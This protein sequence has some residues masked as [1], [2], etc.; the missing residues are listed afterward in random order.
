MALLPPVVMFVVVGLLGLSVLM[1]LFGRI[2]GWSDP[3]APLPPKIIEVESNNWGTRSPV[4]PLNVLET[5]K[6]ILTKKSLSLDS[7]DPFPSGQR[8]MSL[9]HASGSFGSMSLSMNEM[10]KASSPVSSSVLGTNLDNGLQVLRVK[11]V[12]FQDTS[13]S[14]SP[15]S[16]THHDDENDDD[17]PL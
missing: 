17:L 7:E 9:D 14:K 5:P 8:G 3:S 1:A 12:S 4:L 2:F 15:S 13:F 6:S 10:R 16:A 11:G